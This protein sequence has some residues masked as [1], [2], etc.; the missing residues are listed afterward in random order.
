MQLL[1]NPWFIVCTAI[2]ILATIYLAI[3]FYYRTKEEPTLFEKLRDLG[4]LPTFR[5]P[6]KKNISKNEDTNK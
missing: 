1:S 3:K 4:I 6:P 2:N 5:K